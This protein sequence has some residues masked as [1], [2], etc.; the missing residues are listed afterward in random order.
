[1][2]GANS[3]SFFSFNFTKARDKTTE[4]L[5]VFKINLFYI[6]LAKITIHS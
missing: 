3:S 6:A 2:A 1:M 5:R 4:Q